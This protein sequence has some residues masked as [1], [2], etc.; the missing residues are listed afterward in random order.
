LVED[1][2]VVV[3]RGVGQ[4]GIQGGDEPV[5]EEGGGGRRRRRRSGRSG[6]VKH[7]HKGWH[8]SYYYCS[9]HCYYYLD[10][11]HHLQ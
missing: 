10:Y 8:M 7:P 2:G 4:E 9:C 11:H 5:E 6:G 3:G 1:E